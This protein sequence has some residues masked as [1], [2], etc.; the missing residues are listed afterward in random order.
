[1][2][3]NIV[4]QDW[5]KTFVID[6]DY[7]RWLFESGRGFTADSGAA[8]NSFERTNV[9]IVLEGHA[10]TTSMDAYGVIDSLGRDAMIIVTASGSID[11]MHT[12]V[13]LHGDS[14]EIDNRGRIEGGIHGVYSTGYD[15]YFSNEGFIAGGSVGV[16]MGGGWSALTNHAAGEIRGSVTLAGCAGE[17]MWFSNHG[18]VS[19]DNAVIGGASND[20]VKNT[21]M[22]GGFV[23]LGAGDDVLDTR[24]GN[25]RIARVAGGDGDDTLLVSNG[26]YMLREM[27]GGGTDTVKSTASYALS[28]NVETLVLRG[29][30][31][32][33]GTGNDEDNLILGNRSDNLLTGVDGDDVLGGRRGNDVLTGGAGHDTFTF[34]S[35]DGRDKITDFTHGEDVIDLSGW[36]EIGSFEALLARATDQAGDVWIRVG[37]DVLVIDGQS[38]VDLHA[39]DFAF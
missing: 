30:L 21:G 23:S 27:A 5:D 36:K 10:A 11:G 2:T 38:R 13:A 18:K 33:D 14:S 4:D 9:E 32:I 12:G 17:T 22:L 26:N 29:K 8:I 28:D 39:D 24:F 19:A 34:R 16:F 25:L 20:I 3:T 37:H 6:R 1:M 31:N 35:G 7:Q 15:A